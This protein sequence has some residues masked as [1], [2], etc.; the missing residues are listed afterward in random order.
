MPV[1]I[2]GGVEEDKHARRRV[3]EKGRHAERLGHVDRHTRF[4]ARE[5]IRNDVRRTVLVRHEQIGGQSDILGKPA[6]ELMEVLHEL[7]LAGFRR[8]DVGRDERVHD[9]SHRRAGELGTEEEKV[10][11]G[12]G[13]ELGG[14]DGHL[15]VLG[16]RTHEGDSP[17]DLV[18]I[19]ADT[20]RP[21]SLLGGVRM[22]LG[23]QRPLGWVAL[24]HSREGRA[25]QVGRSAGLPLTGGF[26]GASGDWY[27]AERLATVDG[28]SG[29]ESFVHAVHDRVGHGEEAHEVVA[30]AEE[31][32]VLSDAHTG[33]DRLGA[34]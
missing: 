32:D 7:A 25:A 30:E 8:E 14:N 34:E 23:A 15:V 21:T 19:A 18:Q 31:L 17:H 13:D 4:A 5:R 20:R 11:N 22:Q 6:D 24:E 10:D 27:N 12:T 26:A 2:E 29:I 3:N 28:P 1:E 33:R 9:K 16:V